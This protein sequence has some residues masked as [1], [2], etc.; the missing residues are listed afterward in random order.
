MVFRIN[1]PL[2]RRHNSR[3]DTDDCVIYG[4]LAA[5]RWKHGRS[6]SAGLEGKAIMRYGYAALVGL[7]V[8]MGGAPALADPF[9]RPERRAALGIPE[10][11][12]NERAVDHWTGAWVGGSIGVGAANYNVLGDFSDEF[13][14]TSFELPN[15]GG[16]G[17]LGSVDVG[18]SAIVA[19]RLVLGVQVDYAGS[20]IDNVTSLSDEFAGDLFSGSARLRAQHML[21]GALIAGY[22]TS[23]TTQIYSLAGV[24]RGRFNARISGSEDGTTIFSDDEN[25]D[26]NGLTLGAG[27]ERMVSD[28]FSVKFEYRYTRFQDETILRNEFGS[29]EAQTSLHTTRIGMNYRF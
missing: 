22:L 23:D 12:S 24:T 19:E 29:V 4:L 14:S 27:V 6:E 7:I 26:L 15:F 3:F 20:N 17:F 1:Q 16:E 10:P 8:T 13:G 21:T 11:G 28:L 25:V 18:Y 5:V 9:D 2:C